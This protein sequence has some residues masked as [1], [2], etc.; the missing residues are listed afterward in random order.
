MIT[1]GA[2]RSG[3]NF[4]PGMFEQLTAFDDSPE[5]GDPACLCSYC[6]EVIGEEE[7]PLRMW[8]PDGRSEYRLHMPK[9]TD[10]VIALG[11]T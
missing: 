3:L 6:G 9:C 2:K 5:T 4:K 10:Q 11:S 8:P 1:Q 7:S